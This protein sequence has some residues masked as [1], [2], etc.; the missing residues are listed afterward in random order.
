MLISFHFEKNVKEFNKA[1]FEGLLHQGL[2][3]PDFMVT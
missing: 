3:E 2:S 1:A